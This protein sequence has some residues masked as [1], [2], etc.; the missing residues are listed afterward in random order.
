[1]FSLLLI[2]VSA[3]MLQLYSRCV[4]IYI[5]VWVTF[6]RGYGYKREK[7]GGGDVFWI[8]GLFYMKMRV[9]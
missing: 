2:D 9:D 8:V 6:I 4:I 5:I 1:M 7:Y 3:I